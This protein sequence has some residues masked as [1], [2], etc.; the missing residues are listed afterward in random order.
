MVSH[1]LVWQIIQRLLKRNRFGPRES[2]ER[3][4]IVCQVPETLLFSNFPW[5]GVSWVF[6]AKLVMFYLTRNVFQFLS[7]NT[8]EVWK[9]LEAVFCCLSKSFKCAG[10][11]WN[12][13]SWKLREMSICDQRST[14]LPPAMRSTIYSTFPDLTSATTSASPWITE[15]RKRCHIWGPSYRHKTRFACQ[16]CGAPVCKEHFRVFCQNCWNESIACTLVFVV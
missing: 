6:T 5:D 12:F 10:L 7:F 11:R 13:N 3:S 1:G 14:V 9:T 16:K 8:A 4:V 2:F 15:G